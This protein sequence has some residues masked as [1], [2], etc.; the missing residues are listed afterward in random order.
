MVRIHT[1]CRLSLLAFIVGAGSQ[2]QAQ[3]KVEAESYASSHSG[4]SPIASE[5]AGLSIGYFDE[6]GE[7][8]TYSVTVPEAGYYEFSLK[9]LAGASGAIELEVPSGAK[10]SL[11]HAFLSADKWW[12]TPMNNWLA[13]PYANSPL[14]YLEKGSQ[15]LVFRNLG[16]GINLDYFEFAKTS[17]T[18][19]TITDIV[20]DPAR[21]ELM[22]GKSK[23]LSAFGTSAEGRIIASSISWS[24]NAPEGLFAA[25]SSEG[26]EK[27]TVTVGGIQKDIMVKIAQPSKKRNYV[28]S[29]W[30]DLVINAPGGNDWAVRG[31]KN[32][33]KTGFT[34]PSFFWSCSSPTWWTKETVDWLVDDW[35]IQII[36]CPVSIAP[37]LYNGGEMED[38]SGVYYTGNTWNDDNYLKN[39]EYARNMMDEMVAAAIEN[40]IYV[41]ID[42]HDHYSNKLKST[43]LDF[44]D[45]FSKKWGAYPNVMYEIFNEPFDNSQLTDGN[46]ADEVIKKIRS[47]DPDN[48]II[49]GSGRFSRN[50][51]AASSIAS[52]HHNVACTWH[53]YVYWNHQMDWQSSWGN[54]VPVVVTEWGR[55]GSNDGG[56]VQKCKDA[57]VINCPWSMFNK[58]TEGDENWS[59]FVE[60]ST[61]SSGWTDADLAPS[62]KWMRETMRGYGFIPPAKM[63]QDLITLTV[64]ADQFVRMPSESATLSAIASTG[65][66]TV[67]YSW[68]QV[69][70]PSDANISSATLA[71]TTVTGLD[72]GKYQ[73]KL[74]ATNGVDIQERTVTVTVVP[75]NFSIPQNGDLIDN[76]KDNDIVSLWGGS[77]NVFDDHK[78]L[79]ASI[80]TSAELLPV[81][82]AIKAAFTLDQGAW[83]YS[84]YCGV[85]LSIQENEVAYDL[86][87]CEKI[88]Y[89]YKGAA[90]DFR[91]EMDKITDGDFHKTSI[92]AS[93]DWK[94]VTVNW[95]SLAQ[96]PTW[97][98]DVGAVDKS[99]INNFSWQVSAASG[100]G[101]IEIDDVTC[102]G[103]IGPVGGNMPP[104]VYAGEDVSVTS[105]SANL[106][107]SQSFDIEGKPLNFVWSQI[108][109]P[110]TATIAS[111]TLARAGVRNLQN[112][113]YSF[114]LS[115]NDGSLSN[116]DTVTINVS[117]TSSSIT[118]TLTEGWNMVSINVVPPNASV[119]EVFPHARIVK[120]SNGFFNIT[121]APF[122]NSLRTIESGEAYLVKNTVNETITLTGHPATAPSTQLNPGWNLVGV[123][124]VTG[125]S[126]G[127]LPT[128][129]QTVKDFDRYYFPSNA[130]GD[131]DQLTPGK[132]Y[133]IRA[134]STCEIVW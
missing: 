127:D 56:I 72:L 80:I 10:A 30:G 15:S 75:K 85:R 90:H 110:S 39:P 92:D 31:S 54:G 59:A 53:G 65:Y 47:N 71:Q 64:G 2:V 101:T 8:L 19:A 109:G 58:Q 29:E 126:V 48:I 119:A 24:A 130:T 46:Y 120:S 26:V 113:T 3:I 82:Q 49:L 132:G 21:V 41:I 25:G 73:F 114:V 67:Q 52:Q 37:G 69:A 42:F 105:T 51:G 107:G 102:V 95:S 14:F 116:S 45:Y 16:T 28:V 99:N 84:P 115:A 23:L 33:K 63:D 27:V 98:T 11:N 111:A 7:T 66:G 87:A 40:D 77:W 32:G 121:Q 22:P 44:F 117:L 129:T 61:K 122:L 4:S 18:N 96:D 86:T 128:Q 88:T 79:G 124:S 133:Y 134:E 81:N 100:S 38:V 35:H 12:E 9:Y 83:A 94:T 76:I 55:D 89:R 112:G 118:L 34:G 50:V 123:P 68:K 108:A 70:G 36:R 60:G 74:T 20:V 97:G 57:G 6:R 131:L 125:I 106:D 17:L 13:S 1:L 5:N 78:D 103:A 91:A 43:A 93:T 62:G 104:V